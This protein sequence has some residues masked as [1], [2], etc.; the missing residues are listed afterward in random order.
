MEFSE[1]V[2]LVLKHGDISPNQGDLTATAD[3]GSWENGKQKTSFNINLKRLLGTMY[4]EHDGLFILR[5][6]Q[7]SYGY[8]ANWPVGEADKSMT[9]YL[10]GLNFVNSTYDVRTGNNTNKCPI[11]LLNV[12][13]NSAGVVSFSPNTCL[14]NFKKSTD[15]V[16]LTFE[17]LRTVDNLPVQSAAARIPSMAFT[18][19]IYPVKPKYKT[20]NII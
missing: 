13:N 14:C 16:V 2:T 6:N 17:L 4:E 5:L 11:A 7:I 19:D 10:G 15:N 8:G 9:V 1:T 18:F 20:K 3:C 12:L